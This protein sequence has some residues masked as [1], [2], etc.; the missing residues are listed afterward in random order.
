MSFEELEAYL[1]DT[2]A[3]LGDCPYGV[4]VTRSGEPLMEHY[5]AGKGGAEP[6]GPVSAE[7]LW[8]LYSCTKSYI[9]GLILS[10]ADQDILA[11]DDPVSTYLPEFSTPGDGDFGRQTV[12]IRHLATHTSGAALPDG[13]DPDFGEDID[14][15]QV[16]IETK[17]GDV[18]NYTGLGMHLLER[19][20]EAASGQDLSTALHARVIDPLGLTQTRYL[21]GVD[22]G[23][24]MLPIQ[25]GGDLSQRYRIVPPRLR[26]H[27]GIYTTIREANRYGQ[28]W[29]GDG[30]FEGHRYFSPELKSEAW[31]YHI[32]RPVDGGRYGL[33]W[34]LHEDH[35][36][37]IISGAGAKETVVCPDTGI[38]ITVLRLPLGPETDGYHFYTDKVNLARFAAGL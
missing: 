3:A 26:C 20:L 28:L 2:S 12:T 15:G 19:T 37:Y 24:P 7:S 32:T 10:L 23:I 35:G 36:S 11:L 21:K 5:S 13:M 1:E 38:V 27:Y 6:L 14:L 33:L 8:P 29:L 34:W 4:I 18:F 31:K 16:F 9:A 25:T 17:P 22:T 30:T